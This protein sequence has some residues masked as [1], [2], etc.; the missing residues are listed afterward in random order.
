MRTL[1][2]RFRD[3]DAANEKDSVSAIDLASTV[4][5]GRT[6][7]DVTIT[8]PPLSLQNI[9]NLSGAF[10]SDGLSLIHI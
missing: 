9:A 1:T 4:Q 2:G 6:S 7:H 8:I 3:D 5:I 10:Q